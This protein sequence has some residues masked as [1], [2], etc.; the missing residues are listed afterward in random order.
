[1]EKAPKNKKPGGWYWR[2]RRKLLKLE[3]IYINHRT[4]QIGVPPDKLTPEV[5]NYSKKYG[6][7]IQYI[8]E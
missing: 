5:I 2:Q 4:K 8:I 6:M 1:M 7:Q 3:G